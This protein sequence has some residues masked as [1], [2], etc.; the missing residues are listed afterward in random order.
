MAVCKEDAVK[1]IVSIAFAISLY[2]FYGLCQDTDQIR[3][4]INE[5]TNN[6]G[7]RKWE[8]VGIAN[9]GNLWQKSDSVWQGEAIR[10]YPVFQKNISEKNTGN[11]RGKFCFEVQ[12]ECQKVVWGGKE[13]GVPHVAL[14]PADPM[15]MKDLSDLYNPNIKNSENSIASVFEKYKS[16]GKFKE[17]VK[18]ST[19]DESGN[20][21]FKD[22]PV[23]EWI[24]YGYL[25]CGS[26]IWNVESVLPRHCEI[27][28]LFTNIEH[29]KTIE[30]EPFYFNS[31]FNGLVDCR[32][33][34]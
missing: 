10:F 29:K 8:I 27:W 28:V 32:M 5:R 15:L 34:Y 13:A 18:K 9:Q 3:Q 6:N 11:V 2:Q 33:V 30:A 16:T 12:N 26:Q 14:F 20:Y 1:R 4:V 24:L 23:G 21:E 22:I 31:T 19:C 25:E 7:L 17:Q